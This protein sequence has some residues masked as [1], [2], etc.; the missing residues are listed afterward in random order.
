[1]VALVSHG[2][3]VHENPSVLLLAR[4]VSDWVLVWLS[5]R[6]TWA[7]SKHSRALG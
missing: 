4:E 1:M 3:H 7:V 6:Y 5:L 2:D